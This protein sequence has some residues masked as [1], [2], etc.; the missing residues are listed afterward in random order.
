MPQRMQP[1]IYFALPSGVVTPAVTC[2]GIS[3]YFTRSEWPYIRP[4]LDGKT[5]SPSLFGQTNFH[6]HKALATIGGKG[7]VRSPDSD[8]GPPMTLYRS[9]RCRT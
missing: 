5:I 7:T 3:A 2:T 4:R 9:A 8:F 1:S 6:S